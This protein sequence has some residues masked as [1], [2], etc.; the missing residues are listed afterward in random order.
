M[1]LMERQAQGSEKME[2]QIVGK[3]MKEGRREE[4]KE[5]GGVIIGTL[6]VISSCYMG[7]EILMWFHS[8]R[9]TPEQC[10][11]AVCYGL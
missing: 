11:I 10:T 3:I 1:R 2:R 7:L 9:I 8:H 6:N 4:K 5:E